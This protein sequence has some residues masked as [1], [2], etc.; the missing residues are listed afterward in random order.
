MAKVGQ[1][2]GGEAI[3]ARSS[4]G[5]G[6]AERP[7]PLAEERPLTKPDS[8]DPGGEGQ[9]EARGRR[10]RKRRCRRRHSEACLPPRTHGPV[11]PERG[12]RTSALGNWGADAPGPAA[13]AALRLGLLQPRPALERRPPAGAHSELTPFGCPPPRMGDVA[14]HSA[15]KGRKGSNHSSQESRVAHRKTTGT[16]ARRNDR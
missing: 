12:W 6:R 2:E 3:T 1:P 10:E 5:T 14:R 7:P 15:M 13:R 8:T 11:Q 9:G 16:P 4:D